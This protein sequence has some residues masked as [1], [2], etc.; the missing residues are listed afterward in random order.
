MV[1]AATAARKE[2]LPGSEFPE[3]LKSNDFGR[4]AQQDSACPAKILSPTAKGRGT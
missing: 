4:P 3:A 2:R 1:F